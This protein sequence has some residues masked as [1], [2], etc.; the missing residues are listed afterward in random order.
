MMAWTTGFGSSTKDIAHDQVPCHGPERVTEETT[1][2][3]MEDGG[4]EVERGREGT[5]VHGERVRETG[6]CWIHL[7]AESGLVDAKHLPF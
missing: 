7:Q 4:R 3:D 2:R 6:G 1:E 5:F